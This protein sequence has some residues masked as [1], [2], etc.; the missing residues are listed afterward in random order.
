MDLVPKAPFEGP[1]GESPR[2]KTVAELVAQE[3]EVY[4]RF[5]QTDDELIPPECEDWGEDEDWSD[6]ERKLASQPESPA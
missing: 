6:W 4:R 1:P 3:E 2:E 5:P